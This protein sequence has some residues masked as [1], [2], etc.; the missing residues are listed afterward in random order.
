METVT[1]ESNVETKKDT[2]SQEEVNSI[3]NDR[4]KR[5][6]A[7]YED[8]EALKEKAT[9]LDQ[10]EEANKT[11]LEK[12][13]ERSSA[14]EAELTALKSANSIREIR[15]KVSTATGVPATLLTAQTEEECLEQ[16]RAITEYA[17]P[18]SYPV[19][20]DGG[21]LQ[22]VSKPTTKQQFNEWATKAFS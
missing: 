17:K 9:R 10:I 14:L 5:E 13:K 16:A 11:E 15:E 22:N 3:V 8:Y 2:F 19:V 1:Q 4:L 12:E 20:K 21:E 18:S 7:K 6:R